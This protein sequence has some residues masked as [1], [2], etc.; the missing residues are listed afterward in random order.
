LLADVHPQAWEILGQEGGYFL[1]HAVVCGGAD[2]HIHIGPL[3]RPACKLNL[4]HLVVTLV[5][6]RAR[7]SANASHTAV[8][9]LPLEQRVR[10]QLSIRQ[11]HAQTLAW[12]ELR[13][14]EDLAPADLAHTGGDG[15]DADGGHNVCRRAIGPH[16]RV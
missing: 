14:Q 16:L 3:D 9:N 5:W 13:R 2:A 11:D 4:H 7:T 1:V 6:N 15:S 10:L 8:A 12:P